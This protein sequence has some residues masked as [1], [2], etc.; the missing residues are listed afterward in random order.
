LKWYDSLIFQMKC[1]M[2]LSTSHSY[3]KDPSLFRLELGY[4]V[5]SFKLLSKLRLSCRSLRTIQLLFFFVRFLLISWD[6]ISFIS[7]HS[8]Y[9][10]IQLKML[11]KYWKGKILNRALSCTTTWKQQV[12]IKLFL[13]FSW[14]NVIFVLQCMFLPRCW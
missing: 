14:K 7:F 11:L 2:L 1:R 8:W 12:A 3:Y 13:H 10:N 4:N 5:I 6:L 9:K